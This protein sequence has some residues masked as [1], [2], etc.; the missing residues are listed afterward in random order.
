MVGSL[1]SMV[2]LNPSS[3]RASDVMGPIEAKAI[4]EGRVKLARSSNAVRLRAVDALVK[5]IAST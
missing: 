1:A 5:V 4:P 2:G 3:R